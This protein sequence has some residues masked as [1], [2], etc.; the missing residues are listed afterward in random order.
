MPATI[1]RESGNLFRIDI[2]GVLHQHELKN[3]QAVAVQEIARLG[4]IRLLFVLD[5]FV[6]WERSADWGDLAFY[7]AHN[8]DIE[9]I[10]IVGEDKWRH[11]G[12]AFAGAGIR[13]AAARFFPPA[14]LARAR[15]W[16]LAGDRQ[17]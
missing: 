10:A 6:G 13:K 17:R 14:E 3:V 15:A 2:S 1:Q 8:K 4:T 11:H 5:E 16:L 12:L 7:A 9:E